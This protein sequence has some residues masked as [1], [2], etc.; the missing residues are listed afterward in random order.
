MPRYGKL[1]DL[2]KCVGC[3]SC[4][5]ACQAQHELEPFEK[6]VRVETK[7]EGKYPTVTRHSITI[8]CMHCEHP[9]CVEVCP[10]G[11]NYKRRDGIVLINYGR[12]IGCKY[13]V[14][15]C[16]YQARYFNEERGWPDKCWLCW[17]RVDKGVQPACVLACPAKARY[18]G[19][20]D[21]PRSEISQLIAQR[22]AQPL[23]TDLGT[24]PNIYYVR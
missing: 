8:Q 1:I 9:P 7:E 12:C 10:T 23:R 19:D 22:K 14:N 24:G 13:C 15:A 5:V 18:F 17:D 3:G 20:L 21:D 16:P 4:T 6:W 2:T 11:A